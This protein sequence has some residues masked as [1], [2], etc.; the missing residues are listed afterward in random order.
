MYLRTPQKIFFLYP[1][2]TLIWGVNTNCK[3]H[4][5]SQ[6]YYGFEVHSSKTYQLMLLNNKQTISHLLADTCY[7]TMCQTIHSFTISLI[8][9]IHP[10]CCAI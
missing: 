6:F 10:Q 5:Y 3:Y 1:R 7:V 8:L 9:S 4:S 2:A